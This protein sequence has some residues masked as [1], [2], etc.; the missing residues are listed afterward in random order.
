MWNISLRSMWNEICP[1]SQSE[2]FTFAEQI[3]HREAISLARMGKFRWRTCFIAGRQ[4]RCPFSLE[5]S[6]RA[7][8]LARQSPAQFLG[9]QGKLRRSFFAAKRNWVKVRLWQLS[10]CTLFCKANGGKPSRRQ[11]GAKSQFSIAE[12]LLSTLCIATCISTRKHKAK[13]CLSS[14]QQTIDIFWSLW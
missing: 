8:S 14:A 13:M 9:L 1:R 2:H 12:L 6:Y 7:A 5:T 10:L 4:T 11:R 3:F